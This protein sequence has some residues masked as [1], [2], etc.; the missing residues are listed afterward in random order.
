MRLGKYT[1]LDAIGAGSMGTL[2]KA[3]DPDTRQPVVLKTVRR[4]LLQAGDDDFPARLRTEAE[5]ARG[6]THPGIVSVYE[7]GEEGD[8][9][10][11]AMEYVEGRSLQQCFDEDVVFTVARTIAIAS[12]LL[13]ALQYAHDRG[14]WH[15]DVKP[16]NI[17]ITSTDRV[18]VTDFG[19]A[20]TAAL[21][22]GQKDPI[23]G[24]PGFIAPE[25]Y[26]TDTF[27]SRIDVFAAGAVV[28]RMLTGVPAFVGTPDR[29][30]FKVCSETPMAPSEAA[31][32]PAV[33]AFDAVVMRAL[34][35]NPDD[36][37]ATAAEF[38]DALLA[39]HRIS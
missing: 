18:K 17:L 31:A 36:R 34:A 3:V 19:I 12:Q 1:V 11:I 16:A 14:V 24:T 9:A 15:R 6:L 30:M 39:A 26:L 27:D 8:S 7:Y 32:A 28:Y 20:H 22:S 21:A 23:M 13:E 33:R 2:Y 35:R 29:I 25:T 37:F 5:A 4:D 10:Y 38:R